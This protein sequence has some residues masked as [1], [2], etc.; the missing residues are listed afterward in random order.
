MAVFEIDNGNIRPLGESQVMPLS[1]YLD[2]LYELIHIAFTP[3]RPIRDQLNLGANR[4]AHSDRGKVVPR[5]VE[6]LVLAK[7][8]CHQRNSRTENWNRHQ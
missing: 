6:F 5:A 1:K 2:R 4:A 7:F 8:H 3:R